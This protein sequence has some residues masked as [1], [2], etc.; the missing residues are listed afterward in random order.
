MEDLKC[1]FCNASALHVRHL[2]KGVNL[3]QSLSA[4]ICDDCVEQCLGVIESERSARSKKGAVVRPE[5]TPE[6]VVRY[7]NDYVIGQERAKKLLA[8]SVYNHY[9]RIGKKLDCEVLKSNVM[10]VGPTGSGKTLLVSTL[11]KL[12]DVP[13]A[14]GDATTLTEAG[15]VGDDVDMILGRLVVS[16]GGDIERA[17]KGIVY[18]DEIDKI[19]RADSNGR[20]VRGEGVQ[21]A[22]LKMLEGGIITINPAGGKKSP[23]ATTQDIDTTNI[24]FIVGGAFSTLTDI[25]NVPKRALGLG[26]DPALGLV[27]RKGVSAKDLIKFGMIPEFMGRVP[28]VAQLDPLA[29]EDL[30]SILTQPKNSLAKQYKA[31]LALDGTDLEYTD[32]FLKGVAE[33]AYKDGTGARGLRAIMEQALGEIMFKA[34]GKKIKKITIDQDRV[35]EHG[36]SASV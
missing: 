1:S 2:I 26:A 30:V 17:Q 23:M 31:L 4:F 20:D 9:K 16:A 3:S 27:E 7:L 24:L 36:V 32:A 14:V 33:K 5:L 22:L 10:L 19:A 29:V 8:V 18:I 28:V 6:S 35:I 34:P 12:F 25:Q 21:Q 11:A 15:Y 13:F